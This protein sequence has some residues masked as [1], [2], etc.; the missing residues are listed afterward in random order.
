MSDDSL[1]V[2]FASM[3]QAAGDIGSAIAKLNG[4]LDT[5]ESDAS[6]LVHTW[7]GDAQEAYSRRQA[8]WRAASRDLSQM[9]QDIKGA[10]EESASHYH[11][12]EKKNT[13]LFAG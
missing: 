12:T 13:G 9:L 1:V 11:S 5:L 10:L 8:Q 4:S 2:N 6:K 3:Q 7:E